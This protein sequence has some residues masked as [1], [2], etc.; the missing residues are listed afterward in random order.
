M[1][2]SFIDNQYSFVSKRRLKFNNAMF[3]MT[4]EINFNII[5]IIY[6]EHFIFVNLYANITYDMF[7]KK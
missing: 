5:L 4:Q 2:V 6:N 7:I 1:H 3:E